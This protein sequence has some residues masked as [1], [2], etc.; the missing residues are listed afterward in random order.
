M[1]DLVFN[2]YMTALISLAAFFTFSAFVGL[3]IL[4]WANEFHPDTQE[5][6]CIASVTG[7]L[8]LCVAGTFVLSAK[9]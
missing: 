4:G 8:L 7:A 5:R 2:I 3:P 9:R 1:K 6:L